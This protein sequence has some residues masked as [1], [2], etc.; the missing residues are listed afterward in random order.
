MPN[1]AVIGTNE[2]DRFM[3]DNNLW[4]ISLNNTDYDELEKAFINAKLSIDLLL[5]LE[6]FIKKQSIH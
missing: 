4:E 1:C 3:K 6:S 2:F 5:R